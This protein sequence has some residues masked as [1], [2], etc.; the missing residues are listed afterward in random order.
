[1]SIP[2][3]RLFLFLLSVA[4]FVLFTILTV[5][6]FSSFTSLSLPLSIYRSVYLPPSPSPSFSPSPY[7]PL[8]RHISAF[9]AADKAERELKK[10]LDDAQQRLDALYDKQVGK[11]PLI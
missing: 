2:I 8:D 5:F 1:M 11:G 4:S 6:L 10:R 3:D 7:L 9:E